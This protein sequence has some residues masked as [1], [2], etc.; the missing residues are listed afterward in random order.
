MDEK[1]LDEWLVEIRLKGKP[2]WN[3]VYQNFLGHRISNM[4]RFYRAVNLYG[5]LNM[6]EAIVESGGRN[7]NGDTLNYVLKV[8]ANKW[9]E[10]QEENEKIDVYNQQI[11]T[12]KKNS[13]AHIKELDR[14]LKKK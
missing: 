9:R 1:P 7:L 6:L 12:A 5:N 14:K 8:A 2:Y 4:A 11:A 13:M 3:A 10:H